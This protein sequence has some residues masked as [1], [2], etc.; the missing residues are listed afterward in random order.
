MTILL[1]IA[2]FCGITIIVFLLAIIFWY[3]I[4]VKIPEEALERDTAI[5]FLGHGQEQAPHIKNGLDFP[6]YRAA[7]P[8]S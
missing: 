4:L 1:K 8:L 2:K 3:F 5:A 6:K 7:A